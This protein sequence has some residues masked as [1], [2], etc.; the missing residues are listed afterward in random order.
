MSE[1]NR[2]RITGSLFLLSVAVIFL[3]MLFDGDGVPG[4][5]LA[6]VEINDRLP[7][8]Q[9]FD[10]AAPVSDYAERVAELR[11]QAD[12][13]GFHRETGTRIGEPV[14]GIP[15]DDTEAWAVQLGS[16]AEKDRAVAFRDLL[17]ADGFEAFITTYKPPGGAVLNRVAIGPVQKAARAEDLQRQL[18]ERYSEEARI[19]AFGS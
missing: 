16:F 15:N 9:R 7:A 2:Y 8:V 1:Q 12:E 19:M 14:L 6:P 17:R 5:E 11:A 13:Q 18:S 10:A 3:P 4:V